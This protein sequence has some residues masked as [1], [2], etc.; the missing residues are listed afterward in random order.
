MRSR[1][2]DPAV[3][4][5]SGAADDA[6]DDAAG[7]A[8]DDAADGAVWPGM[9]GRAGPAGAGAGAA[10]VGGGEMGTRRG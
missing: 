7:S 5:P 9:P 10:L 1:V 2:A 4:R 8:A 3:G 6:A